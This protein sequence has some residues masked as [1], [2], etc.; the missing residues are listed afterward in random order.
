MVHLDKDL[1][2]KVHREEYNWR[3][4]LRAMMRRAFWARIPVMTFPIKK[5]INTE[6]FIDKKQ[7]VYI[8]KG[9]KEMDQETSDLTGEGKLKR[10][11]NLSGIEN[12][13]AACL[14]WL[15]IRWKERQTYNLILQGMFCLNRVRRNIKFPWKQGIQYT[16]KYALFKTTWGNLALPR[17]NF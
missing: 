13:M 1:A 4:K 14:I 15:T 3:R 6:L 17:Y 8:Q 7:G 9:G 16:V 2:S 11:E 5:R 10:W 12:I